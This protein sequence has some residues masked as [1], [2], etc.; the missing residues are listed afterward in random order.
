MLG[1]K[2]YPCIL[3]TGTRNEALARNI[4]DNKSNEWTEWS[5]PEL[6]D[7]IT[8]LDTGEFD[9]E[10]TGFTNE[11]LEDI[12]TYGPGTECKLEETIEEIKPYCKTHILLSFP[13]EK[14][15]DIK[16]HLEKIIE[17]DGVEYEQASN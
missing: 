8:E 12:I 1:M 4:A 14:L 6:K 2:E 5:Y 16:E 3:F 7:M 17:V 10:L 11:E 13:P 9:I 15:A